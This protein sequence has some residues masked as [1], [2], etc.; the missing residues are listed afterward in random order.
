MYTYLHIPESIILAH[1]VQTFKSQTSGSYKSLLKYFFHRVSLEIV[2]L[3]H[4]CLA[5]TPLA[6]VQVQVQNTLHPHFVQVASIVAIST[7]E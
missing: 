5:V 4:I 6:F 3:A 2:H 1:A 7:H